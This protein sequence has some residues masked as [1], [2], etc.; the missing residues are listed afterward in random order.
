MSLRDRQTWRRSWATP[1]S[2]ELGMVRLGSSRVRRLKMRS[3]EMQVCPQSRGATRI[4][5]EDKQEG[6]VDGAGV[7]SRRFVT[8]RLQVECANRKGT[9][10]DFVIHSPKV[11]HELSMRLHKR[12]GSRTTSQRGG[13]VAPD[14]VQEL[15]KPDSALGGVRG[16]G[17]VRVREAGRPRE[18]WITLGRS[19]S[20]ADPVT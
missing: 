10:R 18:S 16:A 3:Q 4:V 2:G 7:G 12:A 15:R 8:F 9:S 20:G 19:F 14:P 6:T 13:E 17:P 11:W 1:L 5:Y